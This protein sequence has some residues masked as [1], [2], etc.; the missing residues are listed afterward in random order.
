MQQWDE[1]QRAPIGPGLCW[2]WLQGLNWGRRK[3]LGLGS[4]KG[5]AAG[6]SLFLV[7]IPYLGCIGLDQR[8]LAVCEKGS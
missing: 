5:L 2:L 1:W 6:E 8:L 3:K 7:S 4:S